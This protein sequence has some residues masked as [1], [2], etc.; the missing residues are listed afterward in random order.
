MRVRGEEFFSNKTLLHFTQCYM[1][2]NDG[3]CG[4]ASAAE[5]I[6]ESQKRNHTEQHDGNSNKN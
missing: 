1:D 3:L 5:E 6:S 4:L 2:R